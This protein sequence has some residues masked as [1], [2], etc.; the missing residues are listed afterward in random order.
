MSFNPHSQ[1]SGTLET[2]TSGLELTILYKDSGDGW[3]TA[4]IP[5]VPGA[6]SQGRTRD[7]ARSMVLEA[8]QMMLSTQPDEPSDDESEA[9]SV[10]LSLSS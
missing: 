8:L 1:V 3:I 2:V 7:E 5:G 4:I 9:E 6:F 10:Y